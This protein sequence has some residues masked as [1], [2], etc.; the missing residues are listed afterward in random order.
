MFDIDSTVLP[1]EM[2]AKGKY[3]FAHMRVNDSILLYSPRMGKNAYSSALAFIKKNNLPWQFSC[4][5]TK[6]GWRL[7]RIA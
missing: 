7:W 4:R 5:K 1:P 2:K 3:P 6:D